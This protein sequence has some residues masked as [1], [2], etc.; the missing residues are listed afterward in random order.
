MTD[1]AAPKTAPLGTIR[2]QVDGSIGWLIIDNEPKKNALSLA[3]WQAV[4]EAV[5]QLSADPAIRLIVLRGAGS[6]SFVAGADISE[7]EATRSTAEKAKTYD[8]IN[9][10]ACEALKAAEKPTLAMIRGHCLGGGL[11]LALACDMRIA[12]QGSQFGIPAARLGLAYPLGLV[13]DA[14]RAVPAATA[15]RLIFT[16]ERLGSEDA[17]HLGLI[18]ELVDASQLETRT[19]ALAAIISSNAPLT[20]RAA[21]IAINALSDGSSP[22]SLATAQSAADTC[23]DSAD[24]IEGRTAFLEKRK[25]VFEGK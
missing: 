13:A 7:F 17:L 21:K 5:N 23:F 11:A 8:E 25:P 10:A 22:E 20:L 16:A 9:V 12:A 14:L 18:D 4:P 19:Q 2:T 6:E 1:Q 24:F 3:M 15:K